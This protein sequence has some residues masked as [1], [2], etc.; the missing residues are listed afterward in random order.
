MHDAPLDYLFG[1]QQF[2]I[3]FGLDNMRAIVTA[4]DSPHERYRSLHVAGTNGKGSVSAM[5][6]ASLRA[7]GMRTGRFTSPHL[8]RLAERFAVDG[9]PV[10][11]EEVVDAVG[12]VQRTV[13][14]LLQAGQLATHPTFFEVT[15]A[16]AF[17]IFRRRRVDVAVCEVGMGGR[18]DATNVLSPVASAITSVGF[19]HQQ[20]LGTTLTEIAAEKAGIVKPGTPVVVGRLK[21]A[22]MAVVASVA[23]AQKAPLHRA[24]DEVEVDAVEQTSAGTQRFRASTTRRGYGT[25]DLSLAGEHQIDN[26]R[27]AIRMLE[28]AAEQGVQVNDKALR[29]G[30]STVRWPGRLELRHLDGGRSLLLDA[31]HNP[32]GAATLAQYLTRHGRRP[33]VFSAMKDKDIRGI[34]QAL[35]G[36][37]TVLVLTEA[38]HPRAASASALAAIAAE[39]LP[40]V[41]VGLMSNPLAALDSA[42]QLGP[43]V[44]VAGSIFLLGDVMKHWGVAW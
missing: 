30:L 3:K 1:L 9:Q 36:A 4:M 25:L 26:A 32:D 24:I 23:E 22:A 6:E 20:Y 5:L 14:S 42:W 39:V 11:D 37:V 34:L 16:A 7:A 33:L 35:R 44:A 21:E 43:D 2:G 18:L 38:S 10:D 12:E 41:P 27:V 13:A 17:E 29:R 28:V 15:T 40:D 31:A 19:D 8:V